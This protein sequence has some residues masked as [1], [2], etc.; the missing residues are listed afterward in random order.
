M[1]CAFT[2]CYLLDSRGVGGNFSKNVT[3]LRV[4]ASPAATARPNGLGQA[5][6]V[7]PPGEPQRAVDGVRLRRTG[8]GQGAPEAMHE[9]ARQAQRAE[10][11]TGCLVKKGTPDAGAGLDR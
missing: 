10:G 5:G 11:D 2:R 6:P 3:K 8:L 4:R 7:V 1:W 9:R